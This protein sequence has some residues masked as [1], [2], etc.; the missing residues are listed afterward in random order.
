V[1]DAVAMG[2]DQGIRDLNGVARCLIQRQR[3]LLEPMSQ[4]FALQILHYQ[5]IRAI[6]L[7]EIVNV[8]DVRVIQCGDRTCFT[9]QTFRELLSRDF[10]GDIAVQALVMCTID[11]THPTRPNR[12]QNFIRT[13]PVS[14]SKRHG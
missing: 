9:F 11:F 14:G 10:D 8:T 3:S 5:E 13:E 7:A 12:L 6:M 2:M 1:D 4:R